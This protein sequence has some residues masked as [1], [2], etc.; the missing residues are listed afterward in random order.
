MH[1]AATLQRQRLLN[2]HLHVGVVLLA[3]VV[4][5][6]ATLPKR[7]D[8]LYALD[9]VWLLA[10]VGHDGQLVAAQVAL[11]GELV[12]DHVL[13]EVRLH[14][15]LHGHR[16]A[17]ALVEVIKPPHHLADRSL[18]HEGIDKMQ[19]RANLSP[20]AARLVVV[21]SG[22]FER[23]V[24]VAHQHVVLF[25]LGQTLVANPLSTEDGAVHDRVVHHL[26]LPGT[27][28]H[29]VAV[30]LCLLLRPLLFPYRLA[31]SVHRLYL[32]EEHA[33]CA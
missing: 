21:G 19:F 5:N 22:R 9:F 28:A 6:K 13:H 26:L 18:A 15:E 14:E 3:L 1:T 10:L 24:G 4:E 33:L 7:T 25:E 23:R 11:H 29:E 17:C 8:R 20:Q 16:V 2:A 12:Q 30:S 32:G 27:V 31:V